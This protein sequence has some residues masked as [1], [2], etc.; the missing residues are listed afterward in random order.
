MT[1][2]LTQENLPEF[3]FT[4]FNRILNDNKV[5]PYDSE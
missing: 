5:S 3:T 2:K 4:A 1:N